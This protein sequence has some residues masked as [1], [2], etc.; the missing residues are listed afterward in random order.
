M[1]IA[2]CDDQLN[3][4]D[5]LSRLLESWQVQQNITLRYKTFRSAV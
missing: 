4:L 3:E 1:Y 5:H 2:V